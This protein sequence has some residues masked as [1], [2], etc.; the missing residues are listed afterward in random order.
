MRL[1]GWEV[2]ENEVGFKKRKNKSCRP[3]HTLIPQGELA[4][5]SLIPLLWWTVSHVCFMWAAVLLK[6]GEGTNSVQIKIKV[7]QHLWLWDKC[8]RFNVSVETLLIKAYDDV[9]VTLYNI[10]SLHKWHFNSCKNSGIQHSSNSRCL[11]IKV[12]TI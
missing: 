5:P 10:V 8:H 7:S 3:D 12:N 1:T 4:V 2:N 9:C 6:L 11:F